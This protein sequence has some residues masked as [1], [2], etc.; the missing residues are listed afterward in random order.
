MRACARSCVS[1]EVIRTAGSVT[2]ASPGVN[3][4]CLDPM[5]ERKSDR[6]W[7]GEG[8]ATGRMTG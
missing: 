5:G 8:K 4:E 6:G 3:N 7:V 2:E 1:E